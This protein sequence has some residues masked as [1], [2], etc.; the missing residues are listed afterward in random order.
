M[1]TTPI[2]DPFT[3]TPYANF[4]ESNP[5]IAQTP[6]FLN[7]AANSVV[8]KIIKL[9]CILIGTPIFIYAKT[10][11]GIKLRLLSI[12]D[13][14]I[15]N[16]PFN[17]TITNKLQQNDA[18]LVSLSFA[19]PLLEFLGGLY[20]NTSPLSPKIRKSATYTT[21][22]NK[23]ISINTDDKRL[24]VQD[25][26]RNEELA[27]GILHGIALRSLS[28]WGAHIHRNATQAVNDEIARQ[29]LPWYQWTRPTPTY[30]LQRLKQQLVPRLINLI[31]IPVA[32]VTRITELAIGVILFPLACLTLANFA[33]LNMLALRG[34]TGYGILFDIPYLIG[35]VIRPVYEEQS[36]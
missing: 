8:T 28:T 30:I 25:A 27:D 11:G 12:I 26:R 21:I 17:Q 1:T 6:G 16:I 4:T 34:L 31:M 29:D 23:R 2:L 18:L 22:K 10:L 15:R 5:V 20:D 24:E 36:H 32:I 33:N 9:A 35:M 13:G 7:P 3:P 14:N 19:Y